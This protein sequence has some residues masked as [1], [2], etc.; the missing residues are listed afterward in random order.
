[1]TLHQILC[2]LLVLMRTLPILTDRATTPRFLSFSRPMPVGGEFIMPAEVA[3]AALE[4]IYGEGP[5]LQK[6][7]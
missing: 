1:M 5:D 6:L 2:L 3:K 7:T 4:E